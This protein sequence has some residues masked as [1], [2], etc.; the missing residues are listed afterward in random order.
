MDKFAVLQLK[1]KKARE[2]EAKRQG[3]AVG[4]V[5]GVKKV[6]MTEEELDT[7]NRSFGYLEPPPDLW[8]I[9]K[10]GGAALWYV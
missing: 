5:L 3:M 8:A 7:M 9:S 10:E 4:D 2:E 1:K 6:Q